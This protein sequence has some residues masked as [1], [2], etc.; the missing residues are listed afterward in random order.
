MKINKV[1]KL[2]GVSLCSSLLL[3]SVL[4]EPAKVILA[5]PQQDTTTT[6]AT[7]NSSN[8][9]DS[10]GV[11][12]EE[13]TNTDTDDNTDAQTVN[14][15]FIDQNNNK[16]VD[17]NNKAYTFSGE[18]DDGDTI[19]PADLADK[20]A[21]DLNGGYTIDSN[22][23]DITVEAG[24]SDYTIKV[25]AKTYNKVSVSLRDPNNNGN[26]IE[27]PNSV[28]VGQ[29]SDVL[30]YTQ[31]ETYDEFP[32][33]DIAFHGYGLSNLSFDTKNNKI[34]NTNNDGTIT[35]TYDIL[36][37]FEKTYVQT[38]YSYIIFAFYSEPLDQTLTLQHVDDKGNPIPDV[39]D[40]TISGYKTG[41]VINDPYELA[42]VKNIPGYTY[43]H[44]DKPYTVSDKND[45]KLVYTKGDLNY[46]KVNYKDKDSGKVIYTDYL[47]GNAGDTVDI[48]DIHNVFG[49]SN[50]KMTDSDVTGDYV[51]KS[52]NQSLDVNVEKMA[53]LTVNVTQSVDNG[54]KFTNNY[55]TDYGDTFYYSNL[56]FLSNDLSNLESITIKNGDESESYDQETLNQLLNDNPNI[57]T[58]ADF[59]GNSSVLVDDDSSGQELEFFVN[60]KA[61]VN[62]DTINVSYQ[63]DDGK[64]ISTVSKDT[65]DISDVNDLIT[66][67]LPK[68]YELTNSDNPYTIDSSVDGVVNL[69]SQVKKISD[70]GN[71][72]GGG[73]NSGGSDNNNNNSGDITSVSET[74]STHPSLDKVTIYD[75]NGK[76]TGE[77]VPSNS[78]WSTDQKLTLNGKTYYRIATDQWVSSDDVYIYQ[79]T[80]TSVKTY[81]DSAKGLVNSTNSAISDRMLGNDSDWYTDRYTYLNNQKYYRIATN[82]WVSANDSFEYQTTNQIV[83]PSSTAKLYNDRGEF[84]KDA[85]AF[86][87][88]T[89]KI[90][91]INGVQM[92]RVATNQW[93]PVTDV[94]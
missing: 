77:T 66:T 16:V 58:V 59:V 27:H 44:T 2:L 87:L 61:T 49:L 52:N 37:E 42:S 46:L 33:S 20:I 83:T 21:E 15:T 34:P 82:E 39:D 35:L 12:D 1:A 29:K 18:Y 85:P 89:D 79:P 48:Q 32:I 53:P 86:S 68:G 5:S 90:S 70:S 51:I 10:T 67:N 6:P 26:D 60:Y 92:Y 88:K 11:N 84:V 40:E 19:N 25:V 91:T 22:Q 69:V 56:K 36:P 94:Q 75:A 80:S 74:I 50:Y 17:S 14:I 73:N 7:D 23:G 62:A 45:I 47:R 57:T 28:T 8:S 24:T 13:D 78:D 3:S 93:L 4:A 30:I 64:E 43:I 41:D 55:L 71:S 38:F 81:S 54:L 72:G 63:T 31:N 76:A 9:N 65:N